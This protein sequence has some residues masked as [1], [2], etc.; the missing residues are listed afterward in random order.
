M[1]YIRYFRQGNHQ[2]YVYVRYIYTVLANPVEMH[3]ICTVYDRIFGDPPAENTV[4]TPYINDFG[5][6]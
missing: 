6:P 5:Q 4:Y 1:V 3:R 2:I